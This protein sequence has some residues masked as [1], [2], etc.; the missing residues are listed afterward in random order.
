MSTSN[1]KIIHADWNTE[2]MLRI[3][4]EVLIQDRSRPMKEAA[5]AS[6]V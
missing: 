2:K 3:C 1:G 5:G 6:I 4:M